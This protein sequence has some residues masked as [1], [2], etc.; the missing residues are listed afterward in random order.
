MPAGTAADLLAELR[1]RMARDEEN[2]RNRNDARFRIA[3]TLLTDGSHTPWADDV[4]KLRATLQGDDLRLFDPDVLLLDGWTQQETEGKLVWAGR[5][6]SPPPPEPQDLPDS[7]SPAERD[8]VQYLEKMADPK[9]WAKRQRRRS[10]LL[11]SCSHYS[12]WCRKQDPVK[13]ASRAR[14]DKRWLFDPKLLKADGWSAG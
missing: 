6:T 8:W 12:E 1:E 13:L 10:F 11:G 7:A 14:S 9:E 2:R 3:G 4:V 5:K